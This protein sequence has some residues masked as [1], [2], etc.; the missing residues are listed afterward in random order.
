MTG[1]ATLYE[2]F[3]ALLDRL[4]AGNPSGLGQVGAVRDLYEQGEM[5]LAAEQLLD[6]VLDSELVISLSDFQQAMR[7]LHCTGSR[8]YYWDDFMPEGCLAARPEKN[9]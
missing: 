9:V 8:R 7:T 2:E 3:A 6:Y 1:Y 4:T 5:R